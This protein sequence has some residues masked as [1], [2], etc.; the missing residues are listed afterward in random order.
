VILHL[1]VLHANAGVSSAM[2][3]FF[4]TL[5]PGMIVFIRERP[6]LANIDFILL[7]V[8]LCWLFFTAILNFLTA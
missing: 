1:Y 8:V 7:P 4:A 3:L 2:M 5:L 6:P